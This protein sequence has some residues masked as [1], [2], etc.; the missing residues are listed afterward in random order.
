MGRRPQSATIAAVS[1]GSS[2]PS[3]ITVT[4]VP[5]ASSTLRA[6]PAG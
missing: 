2:I 6:A 3:R 5:V 4:P 1:T